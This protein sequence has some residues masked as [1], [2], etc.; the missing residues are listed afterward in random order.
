MLGPL[1]QLQKAQYLNDPR[2]CI[3]DFFAPGCSGG[4][5]G[6][7][8][9][10]Q[11]DAN[12]K[13]G[14]TDWFVVY[15][16]TSKDA[17]SKML[18]GIAVGKGLNVKGKSSKKARLSGFV[19]FLQISKN[20]DKS[21]IEDSPADARLTIFYPTQAGR[22]AVKL[23]LERVMKEQVDIRIDS[24]CIIEDDRFPGVW[25]LD[26]PEPLMREAYIMQQDI[27]ELSGWETGRKSEPA[28]MDMNLH[29][30]RGDSK[31]R[32]VLYQHDT[33]NLMNPRGLLIAYAEEHVKPVVSDFDTF[34]VGSRGM[35]YVTLPS[36]Q[37]ELA[38]WSLERTLEILEWPEA[39]SWTSRWLDV[40][41]TAHEEG[42]HP[43][44][45]K[46][47]FGDA[48]SY[49]LT[50]GVCQATIESG[51]VRHGSE[52]FNFFFPQEL[53]EEFLI[54]WDGF[55]DKPW[56]YKS[57]E[58]LRN[59][60]RERIKEG[61]AFPMNPVWPVRDAGWY[62]VLQDLRASESAH[63]P[64][65]SWFPPESDLLGKIEQIHEDFPDGFQQI[66]D[67]H[68]GG[69][70]RATVGVDLDGCERAELADFKAKKKAQEHA[71]SFATML[72]Q[73]S[74][75]FKESTKTSANGFNAKALWRKGVDKVIAQLDS[76]KTSVPAKQ[77]RRASV[78]V[79][80]HSR[81]ALSET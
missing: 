20:D 77:L 35:T 22:K 18:S 10:L 30:V 74:S 57:E 69:G 64:L 75:S 17:I 79:L 8:K 28:F 50:E 44:I 72:M 34:T 76:K 16:P 24:R 14:A 1:D 36:E 58:G 31:P 62:E 40:I 70:R 5:A 81:H 4:P 27:S 37:Q 78:Q 73:K 33:D 47:G 67:A 65:K 53:D 52:C 6:M 46:F 55:P 56:D 23:E 60:L 12:D 13:N 38:K 2:K 9:F 45:P 54:I 51:A 63:A 42:F 43:E 26:I 29:A 3:A 68:T 59:W 7:R 80:A 25:G 49:R 32:V 21:E 48:T 11:M 41:R 71:N 61:Y 39:S 15:R 66:E 19:P